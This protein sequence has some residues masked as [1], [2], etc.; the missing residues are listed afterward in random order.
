MNFQ[1]QRLSFRDPFLYIPC[2]VSHL[3]AHCFYWSFDLL[4]H[5][6]LHRRGRGHAS[7]VSL[8]PPPPALLSHAIPMAPASLFSIRNGTD[9]SD[10][11]IAI[12]KIGRL[13]FPIYI[14]WGAASIIAKLI[15]WALCTSVSSAYIHRAF[16]YYII[17]SGVGGAC[18]TSL[19][20]R[21]LGHSTMSRSLGFPKADLIPLCDHGSKSL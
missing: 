18:P 1:L 11:P 20:S 10:T 16:A 4:T 9:K 12:P 19:Y 13:R 6:T 5:C 8:L 14:A 7:T 3:T 17:L 2:A 15:G 21:S